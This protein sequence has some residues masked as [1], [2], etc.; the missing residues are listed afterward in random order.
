M[1]NKSNNTIFKQLFDQKKKLIKKEHK[2]SLWKYENNIE[3]FLKTNP[4]SF[5][6]YTKSLQKS[7]HLPRTSD[8]M[9]GTA[10]LFADYFSSVYPSNTTNNDAINCNNNCDSYFNFSELDL[11]NIINKMD[12]NKSSS[13]DGIPIIFYKNTLHNI[14]KPLKLIFKSSISQMNE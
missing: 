4:R 10:N 11:I 14:V 3:S 13:P 8:N 2:L 7:N 12:K 5:F 6:S 1:M 9:K